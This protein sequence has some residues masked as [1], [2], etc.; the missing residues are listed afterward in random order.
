MHHPRP[1][2]AVV[3]AGVSGLV[4]AHLL[5]D[6]ADVVVLEASPRA[7]GHA[8]TVDAELPEGTVPVDIGFLVLNGRTYPRFRALLAELGVATRR[9]DMSFSVSDGRDFEYAGSGP[10]ALFANPR[11]LVDRSFLR[12]VAEYRRFNAD[13]RRLL[14]GDED[15]SLRDW[16]A[17]LG[18]S[19]A[20]VEKLIVPQ[21][22]AV[23]SADPAQMWTFPARFLV[24][25]FANHGMLSLR[26]RPTWHT[27]AG[28]SRAYVDAIARRLG[29]RLRLGAEVTA[30]R[31][32]GDGVDVAVRGAQD[33]RFD[34][35][36]LAC[37]SDQALRLIDFPTAG[38]RDVLGAVPYL[39]SELALHT[40]TSVMPR[41]RA[42]W[43]S[44]NAHL[45]EE[46]ASGPTVTYHLNRLQSLPTATDVMVS[47]NLTGRLDPAKVLAAH[48]VA[49]PTFTPAGVAAQGRW[50][51]ISGADRLHFCGAYW[52]WGFHE[53]GVA[54]AH[55]VA[56]AILTA[57]SAPARQEVAA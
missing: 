48:E 49:H 54:G 12:M 36:V 20:F 45:P 23:W 46:P 38:E 42:A 10:R 53:D 57:R 47:L 51:E 56:D 24:Q 27:I 9:S 52:G 14:D 5:A 26:D 19:D 11:H 55:R 43:A 3:G 7:G 34:V 4:T 21:A 30:V 16:L 2:I 37:H 39:R 22:A 25:F 50:A 35:V 44:W 31:R 1:R 8:W 15:P 28:G 6:R 29:D 13:A 40:D 17:G 18:Y 33:E 41:R 32:T